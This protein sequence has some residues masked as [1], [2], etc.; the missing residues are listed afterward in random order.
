MR[1]GVP[2]SHLAVGGNSSEIS[3]SAFL[4]VVHGGVG[5]HADAH[6]LGDVHL[7][8]DHGRSRDRPLEL[9]HE[10]VV[11]SPKVALPGLALM[12]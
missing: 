9:G 11:A 2:P 8:T 3:L 4:D 6:G 1:N 12:G 10:K 7:E 5:G